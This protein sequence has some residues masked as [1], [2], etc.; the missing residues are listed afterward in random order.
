MT[1]AL[2][3]PGLTSNDPY[4]DDAWPALA[5]RT[6][7]GRA[8]RL[9]VTTPGFE[10][11]L[12]LWLGV[13]HST[14][15][16]QLPILLAS[17]AAVVGVYVL[18]R[19]VGC[20]AATAVVAAGIL[21]LSPM[22]I[23]Y[24]TRIKPYSFDALSSLLT[25]GAALWVWARPSR[26]I[27]W[28]ALVGA[29]TGA[30][31]VSASV[32]PVGVACIGACALRAFTEGERTLGAAAA[33]GF[34]LFVL[35][36][37]AVL[38]PSVPPPLHRLWATGFVDWS[39]PADAL[40]SAVRLIDN[41]MAGLVYRHGPFGPVLLLLIAVGA[42]LARREVALLALG[43]VAVAFVAAAAGRVPLGGGRT[44]IYLYP[45]IALAA[46]VAAEGALRAVLSRAAVP[47]WAPS[48]AMAVGVVVAAGTVGREQARQHPYPGVDLRGLSA[49]LAAA[50]APGDG[51][52]I[53][54]YSRYPWALID[55]APVDIVLSPSLTTGFTV[56]SGDPDQLIMPTEY[57][58]EGYDPAV[59]VGFARDHQRVWYVV[60]DTPLSDTDVE[61]QAHETDT[62]D[63]LLRAGFAVT[64]RIDADGAHAD[65]LVRGDRE[66]PGG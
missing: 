39:T 33:A 27:R 56:V 55:R 30:A 3:I 2:R 21:A 42:I 64:A 53:S 51:I 8:L 23:V 36:Y 22:G 28:V 10:A 7:L 45:G 32:V 38:L 52:V 48:V 50:R 11:G 43:P 4:R 35:V 54:P 31:L 61:A 57:V 58:E 47:K 25:I 49:K 66:S 46:A 17:V 59:A 12:R 41:L 15:W 20:G 65:L 60:T 13:D 6:G 40:E 24:A 19:R 5:T 9:G 1:L 34:A 44:D 18:A 62:E 26:T 63:Q 29:A 14:W 37:A 16:A